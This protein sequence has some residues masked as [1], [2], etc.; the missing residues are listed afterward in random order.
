MKLEFK[1]LSNSIEGDVQTDSLYTSIYATDASVYR[2]IP[3][4]VIYPKSN[5]DLKK[6]LEFSNEH[7]LSITPRA[8]GTSLAGQCV[9]DG[10]ILDL[11]KYFTKQLNFD[12][13]KKTIRLEPGIVRD[14]LNRD[15]KSKRLFFGPNTS[16]SNRCNV[17][18]M[19]GNNSSGTT[20]IKYGVTRDKVISSKGF[21]SDG[22]FIEVKPITKKEFEE[23]LKLNTLEG[24][25]Y[26]YFNDLFQRNYI[27][28]LIEKGFPK[29]SIH[30]RNTGY[31]I[32]ECYNTSF[33]KS[34]SNP[35]FNL[36]RLL[37]GSEGTL[38]IATELEL[39]LDDSPPNHS[40]LI[41]AHF[42][43][44]S[45][46]LESVEISMNHNLYTCEMMDKTILDCTKE[47]M[48][49]KD[50]R[51]FIEK[52]PEAILMLELKSD[53][54]EELTDQ[55]KNLLNDLKS[56]TKAYATPVLK[57]GEIDLAAELRKAGLGL[58]GNIKGDEKAVACIEDTSVTIQDLPHYISDFTKIMK[59]YNQ[60]AVYYAHAGAGEIHLRPILN[61]KTS[62]GVD[63]FKNISKD[64][65]NLVKSYG[66]ALSGEHGDGRVRAPFTRSVVGEECYLIFQKIKHLFDPENLLNPGKIVN[67]KAIDTDLRYETDR[68]EPEIST[69]MD[70]SKNLGILRAAEQCNGSGDCR[71]SHEFEGGMCPSYQ[72]TKNEKDTTRA[73][74]NMLREVLTQNHLEKNAFDNENLKDIF[75]LCI[76][77]KACKN[78]CPS[79]VDVGA[80]KTE[81]LYQYQ[82]ANGV[83]LKTKIFAKN[84]SINKLISPVAPVYN[85]LNSNALTSS[86]VKKT[87]GVA[88]E[89]SL[90]KLSSDSL[91]HK[92]NKGKISLSSRIDKKKIVY[93]FIDEFTNYLD[94][95]IGVDAI[96]LLTKLG[97]EVKTL[98]HE[99]SGRAYFSKGLLNEAQGFIDKNIKI[100]NPVVSTESPLLGIEPSTVLSFRDEY[101][102]LASDKKSAENLS[103]HV[104]LIE[105]FLD[106]EIQ[107]GNL[108]AD[109]FS[110][111]TKEIKIHNHCYQKALSSQIHT[112]NLMN[113]PE[114]FKVTL[115][116]S[117]CCGM[118]GSFGYEKEHYEVSQAIGELV[119]FPAVRKSNGIIC[120]N[121]TSCRHQIKDGTQKEA[122]HP[123]SILNKYAL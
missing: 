34:D 102:K 68:K 4:A 43:S 103:K 113:L 15:I 104:F 25:I 92:I 106:S 84:N 12:V 86:L 10:I 51:F 66:G 109:Q 74:A 77:C 27:E 28:K 90:P 35:Y 40:A 7:K 119:L 61:L 82:K 29:S 105:E 39:R 59:S 108:T 122:L 111:E 116:P 57:N 21:L 83:K 81:F 50:H 88:Q 45:D 93:L 79:N 58:L 31:A 100:F 38:Y 112:F 33:F 101:L 37:C 123:V 95:N 121:G 42:S 87:A 94:V 118:A 97:Y 107:A 60:K 70:F 14:A 55:I 63:D 26:K 9:T 54:Q 52:D 46:C 72:A 47:S 3:L 75:D 62:K 30:R 48:K 53:S 99:E 91:K 98:N 65:A 20:S 1:S 71:K 85:W 19:F 76:S 13:S 80:F 32:D 49:Y 69:K 8:A 67:P 17:G 120:A 96:E 64:V 22:S 115:I 110:K 23:K 5:S 6:I 24:A 18:G 41:A 73:R 117:G 36:N 114:N 78:E 11:S 56:S 2:E 44:I 89:R 16:T